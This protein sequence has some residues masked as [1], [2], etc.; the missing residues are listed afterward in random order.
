[1]FWGLSHLTEEQTKAITDLE[2]KFNATILAFS[3]KDIEYAD[4]NEEQLKELKDLEDKL[5]LSLVT[6]K[7]SYK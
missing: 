7:M 3:S 6:L 1:M 5:G 4:L 2:K